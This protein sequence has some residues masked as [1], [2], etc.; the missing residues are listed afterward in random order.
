[1]SIRLKLSSNLDISGATIQCAGLY[2]NGAWK[3]IANWEKSGGETLT[4][5]NIFTTIFGGTFDSNHKLPE[6]SLKSV[7]GE[8]IPG[9]SFNFTCNSTVDWPS[10]FGVSKGLS[11][12][13]LDVEF[14]HSQGASDTTQISGSLVVDG[15]T[16]TLQGYFQEASPV[17]LLVDNIPSL[18]LS[19]ISK[20]F[21]GAL[22]ESIF[23]INFVN[24]QIYYLVKG[25][26]TSGLPNQPTEIKSGLN[27]S[28]QLS[29]TLAEHAFPKIDLNVGLTNGV[30]IS[31][32][33]QQEVALTNFLTLTGKNDTYSGGP[34]LNINTGTHQPYFK[35]A[36]GI[37]LLGEK[38]CQSE[39][40]IIKVNGN[41][42][43]EAE[44]SSTET[45]GPF[46]K[47]SLLLKYSKESGFE[48]SKWPLLNLNN[49]I[50]G[51][52]ILSELSNI[53]KKGS[54][55][56]AVNF[57]FKNVLHTNFDLSTNFTTTKPNS[58]VKE[59]DFYFSISGFYTISTP[60]VTSTSTSEIVVCSLPLPALTL[61]FSKPSD[62]SFSTIKKAIK[63]EITDNSTSVI[64][65]LYNDSAALSQFILVFGGQQALK[66]VAA[67]ICENGKKK[68]LN[69]VAN[70][71]VNN[72]PGTTLLGLLAAGATAIVT[73]DNDSGEE[74]NTPPTGAQPNNE[75][76][77]TRLPKPKS[78]ALSYLNEK[79]KLSWDFP[80]NEVVDYYEVYVSDSE[81]PVGYP[82]GVDFKR[83]KSITFDK[84]EDWTNSPYMINVVAWAKPNSDYYNSEVAS[85]HI[86]Q[87]DAIK[88]VSISPNYTIEKITCSFQHV[89]NAKGYKV[90]VLDKNN[91][92]IRSS[93]IY[94][95]VES[96]IIFNIPILGSPPFPHEYKVS[97]I[98]TGGNEYIP[99]KFVSN[100]QTLDIG[101][102]YSK[103]G[104]TFNVS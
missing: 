22:S 23:D 9:Q 47:P 64:Q 75:G 56:K 93:I 60:D 40:T 26:S 63:K 78:L 99:S 43:L 85:L 61:T 38:F 79:L 46:E 49:L 21:F 54:C 88:S 4:A 95:V 11:I 52:K 30:V 100:T 1:M 94:K 102:G 86:N 6:I 96:T 80:Q 77:I 2:K 62:F 58:D 25:T 98:C 76:S 14:Q 69:H 12:N 65:Q 7:T 72:P 35:L 29:L 10:P 13:N 101:V 50:E 67:N 92:V 66:S 91:N 17:F 34:Q 103:V 15:K 32:T 84:P 18:S 37:K 45:F 70:Y 33:F 27:I 87:L 51:T 36:C 31:A 8:L 104:T 68:L 48:I 55:H 28:S 73:P 57:V 19:N 41:A 44:L 5:G 16:I 83:D 89:I 59:G 90:W 74:G 97:I 53:N 82:A 81:S 42:N 39:I 20:H 71:L 3:L 24:N